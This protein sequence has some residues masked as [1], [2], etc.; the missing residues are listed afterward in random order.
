MILKTGVTIYEDPAPVEW[1]DPYRGVLSASFGKYLLLQTFEKDCKGAYQ[2][3]LF[4]V[5]PEGRVIHQPVWT[6]HWTAGFFE[7]QK[8]L[9]YWSEWFCRA[10]NPERGDESYVYV[11]SEERAAFERVDVSRDL[12]CRRA[13]PI[14]FLQFKYAQEWPQSNDG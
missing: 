11:F 7:H 13:S 4:V 5:S 12:F 8:S 10:D 9:T 14:K 2:A 3:R 1:L 6:S